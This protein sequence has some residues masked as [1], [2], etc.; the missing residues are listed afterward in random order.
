MVKKCRINDDRCLFLSPVSSVQSPP[1]GTCGARKGRPCVVVLVEE[2]SGNQH[3]ILSGL[4]SSALVRSLH[5]SR[6][7]VQV[8]LSLPLSLP[9]PLEV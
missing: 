8:V 7:L 4:P 1:P 9:F 2:K 6:P 3:T 5:F